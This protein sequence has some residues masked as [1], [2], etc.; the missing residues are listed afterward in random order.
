MPP[1]LAVVVPVAAP[2]NVTVAPLAAVDGVIAPEML[3]VPAG[4]GITS[5]RVRLNRSV[6]GDVSLIVTDVPL[7]GIGA[8][9]ICIQ[10]VSPVAAKS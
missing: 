10:Y 7:V 1:T 8:F 9:A 2:V 5:T 3:R 6:V 4:A